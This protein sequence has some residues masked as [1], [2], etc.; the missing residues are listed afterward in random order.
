MYLDIFIHTVYDYIPIIII[1]LIIIGLIFLANIGEGSHV[2]T[3]ISISIANLL[4]PL[5]EQVQN[6]TLTTRE[7]RNPKQRINLDYWSHRQSWS[8]DVR[9]LYNLDK[10]DDQRLMTIYP[11][12]KT[13]VFYRR[14][15]KQTGI[16]ID[17]PKGYRQFMEIQE[18]TVNNK[19]GIWVDLPTDPN[20]NLLFYSDGLPTTIND[21]KMFIVRQHPLKRALNRPG[22]MTK[23]D[24]VI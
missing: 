4:N 17:S 7:E 5:E 21:N 22:S 9:T 18:C 8:F 24:Y 6:T 2:P 16:A 12:K 3:G 23:T 10:I 14:G 13:R 1:V 20:H 11:E 15:V 19:L